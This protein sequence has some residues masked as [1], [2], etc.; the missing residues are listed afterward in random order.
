[1]SLVIPEFAA[2]L[3]ERGRRTP[4]ALAFTC[5][6][7]RLTYGELLQAACGLA[8][9]LAA[10][11]VAPG[12]RVGLVLPGG[13][14]FV[15]GFAGA[16]LAGAV[17]FAIPPGLAASAAMARAE[18]GRPRSILTTEGSVEELRGAAAAQGSRAS[19]VV[20]IERL[21]SPVGGSP[22]PVELLPCDSEAPAVLQLT[23]GTTGEPRFA[24]LSHRA[25]AAWRQAA[26]NELTGEGEV[27]VGWVPPWHVMGLLRYLMLP[28]V[29]GI[30]THLVP[31]AVRTLG[32]WLE[33]A[34]RVRA[35]FTSA[36]DF[37]LRSAT[38][39]AGG[40]RLD[41]G[42]LRCLVI[43]GEAIRAST[44]RDF[45][46]RFQLPRIVRPAYGLAEAT[47]SVTCARLGE[48]LRLDPAGNVSC[49]PPLPGTSVRILRAGA[50]HGVECAPWEQGEIQVRSA[51]LFSGYFD[52]PAGDTRLLEDGWLATGDTGSLS[53]EGELFVVGRRR[54][55]LK[56]GGATYAPRELEEAAES[57]DGLS[58]A[59]AISLSRRTGGG[60]A[61]AGN[62]ETVLVVVVEATEPRSREPADLARAAAL[63]IRRKVGLLPGEVLVVAP[64]ILRRTENGKL[65]HSELRRALA[66]DE[67]TTA[68][69]L[70]G[71][72]DGWI[73]C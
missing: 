59:A 53:P 15:R 39:L 5:E 11:G 23:S 19:A 29:C 32:A 42:S 56:H 71:N 43:G 54:N 60:M 67:L 22:A 49:G 46:A 17:P 18:R 48:P 63:A 35:T 55:L 62:L 61:T 52:S 14:T 21:L 24:V 7:E 38:R 70:A 65:R 26:G 20:P 33:T 31:P 27:L 66:A 72:F 50:G 68:G 25:L 57:V 69:R 9:G 47:L 12:D 45:E 8:A 73:D 41:L 16:A 40:R 37:G 6:A 30:E 1:M 28:V 3:L 64:G 13:L 58:N 44:I 36:S 2:A 4:D 10:E 34:A 51:S